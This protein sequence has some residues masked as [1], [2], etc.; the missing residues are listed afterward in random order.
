MNVHVWKSCANRSRLVCDRIQ[1]DGE[2]SKTVKLIGKGF[3]NLVHY[4]FWLLSFCS[5][6]QATAVC[7]L[8]DISSG[9]WEQ[10][11]E[12]IMLEHSANS[13]CEQL[14]AGWKAGWKSWLLAT[15]YKGWG[16]AA[17]DTIT[18][19]CSRCLGRLMTYLAFCR[20][21]CC[22]PK[23]FWHS[24]SGMKAMLTQLCASALQV[25]QDLYAN[26]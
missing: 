14:L 4:L 5:A 1:S 20:A 25:V 19:W 24:D 7:E 10:R 8:N 2:N 12:A 17:K 18:W 11:R 16:G 6:K 26:F 23:V 22:G 15:D 21:S 3:L 13:A 9:K